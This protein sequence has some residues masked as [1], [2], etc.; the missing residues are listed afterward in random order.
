MR[1][2]RVSWSRYWDAPVESARGWLLARVVP[3]V[4]ALDLWITRVKPGAEYGAGGFDLAHFTWLGAL[5]PSPT[6][7][8]YVGLVI[9]VGLLA[10]VVGAGGVRDR[11]SW[12]L[13]T[14]A[15][16]WTW[17]MS[18][19]DGY[20]HHVLLSYVLL[21]LALLPADTRPAGRRSA[22]GLPLLT[23][24]LAIVY[25]FASVSKLEAGWWDGSVVAE[26]VAGSSRSATIA[27][28]IEGLGVPPE[29]LWRLAGPAVF[30][31][32]VGIAL[33]YL[34]APALDRSPSRPVRGMC[35]GALAAALSF[36][37]GIEVLDL[38]VGW[39]STYSGVLA[40]VLLS[41]ARWV[42]AVGAGLQA[43]G[44]HVR[45]GV[46]PSA[47]PVRIAVGV[48]WLGGLG[49]AGW[50]VDLPGAVPGLLVAGLWLVAASFT[51]GNCGAS[52]G[53]VAAS[54]LALGAFLLSF[55]LTG[56]RADY[57][58]LRGRELFRQQ[59]LPEALAAYDRG[60][61]YRGGEPP[62][63]PAAAKIRDA[64][65]RFLRKTLEGSPDAGS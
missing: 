49:L 4:L 60:G 39:F 31:A 1:T 17:A 9:G 23:V 58:D 41:P 35:A 57:W 19:L 50:W 51:F 21:C 43:L 3:L 11:A 6:P 22:W 56:S 42:G 14:A 37:A 64:Q 61:R 45:P 33:A 44:K 5:Q 32:E 62:A 54:A 2:L 30:F 29:T 18:R 13:L 53:L 16:S 40:L 34:L 27:A 20:Q 15:Y 12:L 48:P 59:R 55:V 63:D 26:L 47:L 38:H 65:V 10:F 36:H 25:A 8:L 7:A 28:A 52:A 46:S 24:T